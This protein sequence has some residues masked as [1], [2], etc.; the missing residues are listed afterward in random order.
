MY[1]LKEVWNGARFSEVS[2][3]LPT[4]CHFC[5]CV[6]GAKEIEGSPFDG[7]RYTV[8]CNDCCSV[9]TCKGEKAK[10]DPRNI[11]LMGH[12]DGWYPCHS[13]GAIDV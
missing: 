2:W 8:T 7:N 13:C 3:F 6:L 11:A 10:A 4:R 12:W 9:N 1:P 5:S